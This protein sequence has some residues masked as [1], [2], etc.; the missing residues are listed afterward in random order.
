MARQTA[1]CFCTVSQL[2]RTVLIKNKDHGCHCQRGGK[3]HGLFNLQDTFQISSR[4]SLGNEILP[5]CTQYEECIF[6]REEV[7]KC[8]GLTHSHGG[9]KA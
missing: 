6:S 8:P 2:V 1:Q 5:I 9:W 7:V 4:Q 3:V